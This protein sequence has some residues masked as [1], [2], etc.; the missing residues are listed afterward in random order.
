MSI[1]RNFRG[2]KL[3]ALILI[4]VG[5]LWLVFNG[6][7][8]SDVDIPGPV[9]LGEKPRGIAI[10]TAT[11]R[12]VVTNE[13]SNTVSIVDLGTQTVLSVVPVGTGPR[14]V[15]I[16]RDMNLALIGNSKD[17]TV[18]LLDLATFN[19][20]A[21]V[22]VGKSPEGM[23][24]DQ[25]TH[26]AAV[27]NRLDHT[28]SFIDLTARQVIATVPT[29]MEPIDV[30]IL[31]AHAGVPVQQSLALVINN[32]DRNITVIDLSTLTAT[33]MLTLDKKPSSIDVNP[34][35][36]LAVA[37]NVQENSITVI[38]TQTW[39]A[40]I[41][42]VGKHPVDTAI[43]TLANRALVICDEDR[44]LVIVDLNTDAIIRTY[45]LNKL[46]KGVA[47]NDLTGVTAIIDDKTD[48]LTLVQL[49]LAPSLPKV[50]ITSPAD[51]AVLNASPATVAGTVANSANVTVN[52]LAASVSGAAFSA[53]VPLVEG[54]NAIT[55]IATDGYGR[56]AS[57]SIT[58]TLATNAIITGTVTNALTGLPVASASVSVNDAEGITRTAVTATDGA[59]TITG[60]AGGGFTGNI[61]KEWYSLYRFAESA[62]AGE[63][64]L[65]NAV[66]SPIPPLI[67]AI[68]VTDATADSARI[69]W[70]TDQ[71][72]DSLVEYG[73]TTAYGS[74]ATD[75]ALTTSHNLLVTGLIPS[76]T[77]YFRIRSTAV[78]GATAVSAVGTFKAKTQV[79][80]TITAP[81]DGASITGISV[82]VTGTVTNTSSN[83]TG[84]TVNGMVAALT[85][86]SQ[87]AASHVPLKE[88]ANTITV[89]AVDSEG[90]TAVKSI[91]VYAVATT[92]YI[93]ITSNPDSGTAPLEVTLRIDGSFSIAN[94]VITPAGPGP[95]EQLASANP[96]EYRYRMT[97]EGIY[98]FSAQVTGPDNNVYQDNVAVAVF[99]AVQID[100]LLRAKWA[101]MKGALSNQDIDG[102]I[103]YFAAAAQGVY[104]RLF[105]GLKPVLS[106]IVDELNTTQV[107]MISVRNNT[108]IYE[109]IVTRNATTYSFQLQFIKGNDGV[110]K[111]FKY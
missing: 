11:N 55:A 24:I 37:T 87:F 52:G 102:A 80:I 65:M 31:E 54:Q 57:S 29:G 106:N 109:I 23:A 84:V 13:K 44:T 100:A 4:T 39:Q 36:R 43:D 49:P 86:G 14:G 64:M 62:T 95:V 46:P 30:A 6:P 77:Y 48:S 34:D 82:T 27:T 3:T 111:I 21:T 88:G 98:S 105:T 76:R 26:L 90:N 96:D 53:S 99:S 68:T 42:P 67:S 70:I 22:P 72:A 71:P 9:L 85:G 69:T 32:M 78:N 63:T 110:W 1:R 94:P 41:I 103:M 28:V 40:R 15:A 20:M 92:N 83:E 33:S 73:E 56:T 91:T 89:N 25:K 18:S 50:T 58:V 2:R 5:F 97:A 38:D 17:N 104:K 79:G 47:V 8:Y 101:G 81:V 7:V 12:A 59:Y 19:V 93:S 66:L 51:G 60:V 108:A 61:A 35:T 10:N 16:D 75:A 45:A 74:Q 107:N